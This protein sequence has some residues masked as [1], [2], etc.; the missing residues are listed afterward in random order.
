MT[1]KYAHVSLY[2]RHHDDVLHGQHSDVFHAGG[3]EKFAFLLKEAIPKL[4]ILSVQDMQ[5]GVPDGVPPWE[6]AECMNAE[7]V[8]RKLID[9]N[10]VVIGD[11]FWVNGLQGKVARLISVCHGSY[12]GTAAEHEKHRSE[13]HTSEL[14]SR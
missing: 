13:E 12:I 6:S 2:K 1:I 3:V 9:E 10:T 7:L 5:T 11:G 14:Q 4:E 8:S